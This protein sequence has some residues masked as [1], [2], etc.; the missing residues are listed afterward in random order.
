MS[1]TARLDAAM[2][3]NT[4]AGL[5]GLDPSQPL[6]NME[7]AEALAGLQRGVDQ[8]TLEAV[9]AACARAKAD[10]ELCKVSFSVFKPN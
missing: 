3:N 10:L 6:G 9:M 1:A 4:G 8:N 5:A 7:L 2:S